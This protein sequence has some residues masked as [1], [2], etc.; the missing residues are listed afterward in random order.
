MAALGALWTTLASAIPEVLELQSSTDLFLNHFSKNT[1][2]LLLKFPC[3]EQSQ[4]TPCLKP[5]AGGL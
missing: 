4:L 2:Q 3:A 5:R 1:A